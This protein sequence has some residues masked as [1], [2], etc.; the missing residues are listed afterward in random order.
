MDA[1]CS[2]SWTRIVARRSPRADDAENRCRL[3]AGIPVRP[4]PHIATLESHILS[5]AV[6]V[7]SSTGVSQSD[8]RENSDSDVPRQRRRARR[9]RLGLARGVCGDVAVRKSLW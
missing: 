1:D 7:V 4:F 2:E 9:D 8:D 3:D 5:P 6:E